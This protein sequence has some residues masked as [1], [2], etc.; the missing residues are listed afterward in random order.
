MFR[1]LASRLGGA[2][3]A[4]AGALGLSAGSARAEEAEMA[5]GI[6]LGTTYSCIAVWNKAASSADIIPSAE[7]ARTTPSYV[8][9]TRGG[10]TLVGDAAKAQVARNTKGTVFDAKRLIGRQ[11]DDAALQRDALLWPFQVVSGEAGK[12]MIGVESLDGQKMTLHP[13][14]VSAL[15]LAKLKKQAEAHLGRPVTKAV[16]TAPAY[17]ND[18]QRQAT[19]DAGKIAGLDV[20]RIIN[21]P[22]A[23]AICYGLQKK[24]GRI[25]VYDMGGGTFDVTLLELEDG[26]LE[27]R[28]TAGD[29]HLGGQD[30]TNTLVQHFLAEMKRKH[31][32]VSKDAK[33]VQ[34]L[35]QACDRAK[36]ELSSASSA[37]V[38]VFV[39]GQELFFDLTRAKFE[40]L[41]AGPFERSLASVKR[42]LAD[43]KVEAKDVD[44]VVLVGGSTRIPKVQSL[45]SAYFGGK[46]L[47]QS[48]N[49]DEAVAV[50][51]AM[52]AAILSGAA[53][54]DAHL[55]ALVLLDVAPLSLGI[56]TSGGLMQRIVNRNTVVP[57]KQSQTFTTNAD[58]QPGVLI[59]VFE[60][61]RAL[62][63]DCRPLGK[64]G[65]EGIAPAPRGV[66]QVV[67]EFDVDASG[68]LSV[69]ASDASSGK[70]SRIIITSDKGRLRPEQIEEL[71]QESLKFKD[72]DSEVKNTVAVRNS[73]ESTAYA[74]RSAARDNSDRLSSQ[75]AAALTEAGD[76]A[77]H[78]LKDHADAKR[79][80]LEAEQKRLDDV[81]HPITAKLHQGAPEAEAAEAGGASAGESGDSFF[82]GDK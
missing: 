45:V 19:K 37:Q 64:F 68:I 63:K 25:L 46:K 31:K 23:A 34:R 2:G 56:E 3:G 42:V 1:R 9:Y 75:D 22:T 57:T 71:V 70:S 21:E 81:V 78:F 26:V 43:A 35:W 61:E 38:E 15:I 80:A 59:Q 33:A 58:N 77:L 82:D 52:Q 54:G 27:V 79:S 13:E 47:N 28:A 39:D 5:V 12:A 48:V 51:A 76:A 41:N 67:V 50:G 20:L 6:D 53:A 55:G 24:E 14:A 66:P 7:G 44:E 17:F 32:D 36:R 4:Y 8:A 11:A 16:I 65:L 30:F 73:L 10:E 72:A 74:A 18:A 49:V 69:H 40:E 62:T 29:T 60:G